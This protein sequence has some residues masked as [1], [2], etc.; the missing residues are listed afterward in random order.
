MTGLPQ[1]QLTEVVVLTLF[2]CARK[3]RSGDLLFDNHHH[4]MARIP[5]AAA[6]GIQVKRRVR[7]W[8]LALAVSAA[9]NS[10]VAPANSGMLWA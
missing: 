2:C 5:M 8:G 6:S 4:E 3:P 1:R 9:L 10:G 7:P